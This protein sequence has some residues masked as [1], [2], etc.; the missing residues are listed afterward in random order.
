MY[1]GN[2]CQDMEHQGE[3]G[4]APELGVL[5]LLISLPREVSLW[6]FWVGQVERLSP[7]STCAWMG[8]GRHCMSMTPQ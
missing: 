5:L 6:L 2:P 4:Q 3:Q 7:C 8:L 1:G